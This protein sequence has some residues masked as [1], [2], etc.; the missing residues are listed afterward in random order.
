[1]ECKCGEKTSIDKT[2]D[3]VF[4]TDDGNPFCTDIYAE[5][6]PS[7]GVIGVYLFKP[8]QRGKDEQ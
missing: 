3:V 4:C 7:C 8:Q 2:S 6:C 1:M 5:V